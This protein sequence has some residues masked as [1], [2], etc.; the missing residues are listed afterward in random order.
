MVGNPETGLMALNTPAVLPTA[1]QATTG[2][3]PS[4][5]APSEPE[6]EDPTAE[7]VEGFLNALLAGDGTP[8]RYVAPRVVVTAANPPLFANIEVIDQA[9]DEMA[10]GEYRVLA[11]VMATTP[12]GSRQALT[13]ELIVVERVDRLEI[14]QF[15]GAPTLVAGTPE[16]PA[17]EGAE[18]DST[19]ATDETGE[20]DTEGLDTEG[21]DTEGSDG[22]EGTDATEVT[23]QPST[24]SGE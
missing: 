19:E 20:I 3:K 8:E 12:G 9:I 18:P 17:E 22:T 5:S 2:W 1:P 14:T 10:T 13:Y 7:T 21:L 15:A 11:R 16:P 4:A 24:A 6:A 23:E